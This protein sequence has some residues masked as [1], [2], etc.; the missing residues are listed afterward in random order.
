MIVWYDA[1]CGIC[2]KFID[3]ALYRVDTQNIF[4]IPN[5]LEEKVPLTLSLTHYNSLKE[6]TII[7]QD[8][9]GVVY[10]HHEAIAEILSRM[11]GFYTLVSKIMKAPVISPI[12]YWSYKIFARYRHW[13]S[14]L[15]G[16]NQCK[17]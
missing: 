16:L 1:D 2:S 8:E 7:V 15:F 9:E 10:T 12:C 3:T 17:I 11:G 13:I 14:K 6:K 5:N 4:F